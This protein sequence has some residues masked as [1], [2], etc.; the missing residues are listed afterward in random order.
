MKLEDSEL[1]MIKKLI[2]RKETDPTDLWAKEGLNQYMEDLSSKYKI[3]F[4][5]HTINMDTGELIENK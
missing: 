2:K 3:S 5:K 1:A 4:S